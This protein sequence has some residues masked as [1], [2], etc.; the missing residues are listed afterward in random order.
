MLAVP[1][2][3]AT[4]W[5]L[6]TTQALNPVS[7][8]PFGKSDAAAPEFVPQFGGEPAAAQAALRQLGEQRLRLVRARTPPRAK[9]GRT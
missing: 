3:R 8:A 5:F 9:T 2:F 1:A 6:N 7:E 4:D